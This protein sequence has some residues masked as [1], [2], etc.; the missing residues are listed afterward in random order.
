MTKP[1]SHIGYI[2]HYSGERDGGTYVPA[3]AGGWTYVA[4][5]MMLNRPAATVCIEP[6]NEIPAWVES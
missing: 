1:T 2:V 6:V 5:A 4:E 3:L